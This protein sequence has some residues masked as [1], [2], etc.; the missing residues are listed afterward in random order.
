MSDYLKSIYE[1]NDIAKVEIGSAD[2]VNLYRRLVKEEFLKEFI[3]SLLDKD[4]IETLDGAVDT[5]W[6]TTGLARVLGIPLD[7]LSLDIG[8]RGYDLIAHMGISLDSPEGSCVNMLDSGGELVLGLETDLEKIITNI[9]RVNAWA[10]STACAEFYSLGTGHDNA[11]TVRLIKLV[12]DEVERSNYS[13]FIKNEDGS[14]SCI[15]NEHGKIQKPE[16]FSK[17]DV[18]G[19][20]ENFLKNAA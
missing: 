3:T 15:K 1:W 14:V 16:T 5:V 19:I 4:I 6:V 9:N 2:S 10:V 20:F 7:S 17:A 13:K 8:D 18:K 11:D 12:F